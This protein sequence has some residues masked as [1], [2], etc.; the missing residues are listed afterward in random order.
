MVVVVVL[1]VLVV[2][3]AIVVALALALAVA[4][5]PPPSEVLMSDPIQS[6]PSSALDSGPNASL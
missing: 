2:L 4:A 6:P 5:W 1:V 3:V